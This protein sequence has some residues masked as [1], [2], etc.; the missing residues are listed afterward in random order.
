MSLVY[1][2]C[3]V[4]LTED[5]LYKQLFQMPFIE[6]LLNERYESWTGKPLYNFGEVFANQ[7][8]FAW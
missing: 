4:I 7:T 2:H 3:T 5:F 6:F 1:A 8:K